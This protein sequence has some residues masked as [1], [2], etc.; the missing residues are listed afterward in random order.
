M[1][2][3][4]LIDFRGQ[5]NESEIQ[6]RIGEY[7]TIKRGI[8]RMIEGGTEV[9]IAYD[10]P[11]LHLIPDSIAREIG[12]KYGDSEIAIYDNFRVD[13]FGGGS[14]GQ[15]T[16]VRIYS[17]ATSTFDV[18]LDR[19]KNYFDSLWRDAETAEDYLSRLDEAYDSFIKRIDYTSNWLAL[20]EFDLPPDDEKVKTVEI[21]R[22]REI[23]RNRD[24]WGYI[25]RYLDVG[26]CTARYPIGLLDAVTEDCEIFGI[27]ED[28]DAI[29]FARGQ[30]RDRVQEDPR[31]R[32]QQMDFGARDIPDIGS[33]FDLITCMLGTLSHFGS[34]KR[35]DFEDTLQAV[36]KRMANLLSN[37]GLLILG[38]WS[39]NATRT[40][41]LLSIYRDSD[42]NRLAAWTPGAAEL[43]DRLNVARLVIL[44]QIQPHIRLDL[45]VC[46]RRGA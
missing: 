34:D 10:D 2:K 33:K 8:H 5:N 9:K 41:N 19:L 20:Y 14:I 18:V 24:R 17:E 46:Q 37:D 16:D 36:L 12:F 22:V 42:Q 25:K 32:I 4:E 21:H 23:L 40:K 1:W 35:D 29:R 7:N 15:I 6:R 44:E 26:T 39:E 43:K 13:I 11:N 38:N 45:F 27:D 3:Q 28:L 30:C 31:I